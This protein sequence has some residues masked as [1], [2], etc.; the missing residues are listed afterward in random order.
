MR[1]VTRMV[2]RRIATAL[3]LGGLWFL[4]RHLAALAGVH[5]HAS[6]WYPPAG[7][8]FALALIL[9]PKEWPM[10]V[11]AVVVGTA[12]AHDWRALRAEPAGDGLLV[13]TQAL[14]HALPLLAAGTLL[15]AL[16]GEHAMTAASPALATLMVWPL[17]AAGSAGLGVALVVAHGDVTP[18]DAVAVFVPW[19][20]GDLVGIATT[21]AFFALTLH[22]ALHRALGSAA[23]VA[24]EGAAPWPPRPGVVGLALVAGLGLA[25]LARAPELVDLPGVVVVA[26]YGPVLALLLIARLAPPWQ[27]QTALVLLTLATMILATGGPVPRSGDAQLVA[28]AL[29]AVALLGG[30]MRALAETGERDPLTGIANRRAWLDGARR[31]LRRRGG[32]A[33]ILIDL[34]HFKRINDRFGHAVGDEVLRTV[35]RRLCDAAG[36]DGCVGRL[37]GEEFAALV[38]GG[39]AEAEHRAQ[40]MRRAL[41]RTPPPAGVGDLRVRASFGIASVASAAELEPALDAADAA[42]YRAKAAGRDRVAHAAQPVVA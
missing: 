18:G 23:V 24:T 34:D 39:A 14:G 27:T 30:T 28:L 10:I 2:G 17:A 19:F 20:T 11:A 42:L 35:A 5:P 13:L 26:I 3:L 7:L 38:P 37:G 32:G 40:R 6:L 29:A 16:A 1:I 12:L 41:E 25:V 8:T 4:A 36:A 21:G 33:V 31:R 15:R 22:P 9:R